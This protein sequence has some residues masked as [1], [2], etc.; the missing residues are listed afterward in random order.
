MHS[1]SRSVRAALK[2]AS[3][4]AAATRSIHSRVPLAYPLEHGVNDFLS[5]AALKTVAVDWQEGVLDRLNE[6]V[7]G[8]VYEDLSVLQTVKQT[9]ADPSQALAFNY[10]SE[11]LNNSFFLSTLSPSP[12]EPRPN[13]ELSLNLRHTPLS[14]FAGLISHFSA[15]AAGLHPSSGAYL[16]LATDIQGN[17]G[18]IGTY[19]GGTLLVRERRHMGRGGDAV[20]PVLGEVLTPSEGEEGADAPSTES[21]WKESTPRTAPRPSFGTLLDGP[22]FPSS[23]LSRQTSTAGK[24]IHP[25]ACLS[26]HPHCYLGDYGVWGREEYVKRWWKSV[27]W[28]QVENDYNSFIARAAAR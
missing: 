11:A 25:L 23:V 22:A 1:A 24:T 6:L 26:L 27:D 9:A 20:G 17:L 8:T 7:K 10:A 3:S 16:W 18:V 14:N 15:H 12:S 19:A 28:R 4:K 5:P 21:A 2:S 13:S